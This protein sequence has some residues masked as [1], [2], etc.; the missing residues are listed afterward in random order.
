MTSKK[1][2][3]LLF[4]LILN[5][6]LFK[7]FTY[8]MVIGI[9]VIMASIS[10]Y[11]SIYEG[12]KRYYYIS[13]IFISILLIFQYK[14]S[15]INPL[16]FLNENEKIEQQERM[17]GY[18]RHF[19][20][21]ANW[22]EQRKEALIFYKLQ[23]NFFEVMDPNLYFFANHPRERVG[24]V[25][26]EKFPY[27]FLPFLVIGLLSLKKSS[28]KILLLS[29]SPLILLS[30]I[31][32]SNPMG[33]FS[34]FPTLAAF[35]AVGLEPIFKNKKYLFVFLMLFSLVFIQTISYATY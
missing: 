34:L 28:F 13:T 17:R 25:E 6:W 11:L 30:L 4:V 15:S 19:Y 1:I 23:E 26:Y 8:S 31:G 32:N 2:P 3:P 18:P 5:L 14:T 20:R 12:K 16:T 24:V 27:I 10:V 35:I 7:I 21:F 9:T 33:P 22:L 29:S